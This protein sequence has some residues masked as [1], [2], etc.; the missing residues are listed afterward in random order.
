L[1]DEEAVVA[2]DR[3]LTG[4]GALSTAL[5]SASPAPPLAAGASKWK[6][7]VS[8]TPQKVE[9]AKTAAASPGVFSK[10]FGSPSSSTSTP[11]IKGMPKDEADDEDW[12]SMTNSIIT[13]KAPS[14]SAA[15]LAPSP[16]EE[17]DKVIKSPVAPEEEAGAPILTLKD[18]NKFR[19][20]VEGAGSP[21]GD[22]PP[23]PILPTPGQ[24]QF[25]SHRDN[26]KLL[27][28]RR[29]QKEKRDEKKG[30]NTYLSKVKAG[31]A[32]TPF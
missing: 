9:G 17:E 20:R 16:N 3:G 31:S 32:A 26:L 8:S 29:I 25:V 2:E 14:A 18:L 30:S 6:V 21:S 27:E 15:A 22:T 13:R 10:L 4:K 23:V 11:K 7:N 1:D 19:G 12:Q 24:S 28:S 5:R